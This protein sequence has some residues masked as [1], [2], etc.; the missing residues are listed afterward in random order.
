M[1]D[2]QQ[3]VPDEDRRQYFRIDDQVTLSYQTVPED[4]LAEKIEHLDKGLE[5]D[6]SVMSNLS[7]ISQEMSGVLRKIEVSNPDVARYLKSLDQKIELL[8]RAF[9]AW[10][11]DL[12]D[13]PASAVNLSANG[14]A[15]TTSEQLQAGDLLELKLLLPSFTGLVVYAEVIACETIT[16]EHS[17]EPLF[18][19]R[20]TFRHLREN[21]RDLLI[22]HVLQRQSESLRRRREARES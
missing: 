14:M 19:I 9:L 16:V 6:F 21:D 7:V 3:Q 12:G 15:F 1:A 2:D 20:V 17:E 13:Q 10:T 4:T 8:G 11:S 5:S 18:Q 22:R